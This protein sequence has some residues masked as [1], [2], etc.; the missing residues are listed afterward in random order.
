MSMTM[1]RMKDLTIWCTYHND[2]QLA[3]YG[4]Q[5]DGVMKLFKGNATDVE[6]ENINHLNAFYAEICTYYWVWKNAVRSQTVGFCH[7]RRRFGRLMPIASGA[8][9]VL[10]INRN[11]PLM[12]QYKTAHNYQDYYDAI[13]ILNDLY[14]EGNKYSQYMLEGRV[15]IPCCCFVMQWEDFDRLCHFLFPILEAF[16]KRN[17]LNMI[18]DRY[19]E[20]AMRDFRYD[21][22][23]YQRRAISFLAERLVSCFLVCEM[24]AYCISEI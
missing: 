10:A 16:D 14:G 13:D 18:P 5:E 12:R 23:V 2:A 21:D 24:R 17:G 4:L 20:K 8:C 22:V 11:F 6:G 15:F 1:D 9:Q 19:A 3:Q 7:Y